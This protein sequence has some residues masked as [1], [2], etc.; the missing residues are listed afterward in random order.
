MPC[1]LQHGFT[2]AIESTLEAR[3]GR[4]IDRQLAETGR[5]LFFDT[6]VGLNNDN[7]CSGCHSPTAGFGDTQS[8]AIG[9]EN[10][11]IVGPEP[12]RATES[13]PLA[14]CREHGVLPQSDVELAL[15]RRLWRSVRQWRRVRVSGTG[16]AHAVVSAP[17]AG[18]SGVHSADRARGSRGLPLSRRQRRDPRGSAEAP[19]RCPSTERRFGKSFR[20]VREGG[21][22]TFDMFGLAIAEFEFTLTFADA[23]IDRFARGHEERADERSRS[24]ARCCFLA[25]RGASSATGVRA[26]RTRCS[27]TLPRTSSRFRRSRRRSAT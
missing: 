9:I 26:R 4:R 24:A 7:N 15:R 13:A 23:P 21:P 10:N 27:V 16:G 22:I 11:G 8:I 6:A 20:S 17:P 2:G 1:S 25:R 19:R 14:N 5:L 12:R 3:L 18:R